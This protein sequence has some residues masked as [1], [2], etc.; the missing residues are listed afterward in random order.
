MIN[1]S[2]VAVFLAWF[3]GIGFLLTRHTGWQFWADITLAVA[4]GLAGVWL[5]ARFLRFLESREQPLD[6]ADY[7]M[8]GVLGRVSCAI[9]P[10]GVGELIYVRDGARKP[11][12]AR[13][14]DGKAI[15]R[16]EEVIVTRY[17]RGIAYVRTWAAMVTTQPS[18]TGQEGEALQKETR[19][20]Q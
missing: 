19:N 12:A 14:E 3:G 13:S 7:E 15:G 18:G 8:V 20:V 2:G 11:V 4:A 1:P 10:D 9:R 17:E 5:L 6:P 16:G